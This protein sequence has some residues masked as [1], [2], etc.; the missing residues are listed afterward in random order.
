M[1]VKPSVGPTHDTAICSD[2][3]PPRCRC[4]TCL[5]WVVWTLWSVWTLVS[6]VSGANRHS[7]GSGIRRKAD[8]RR[9]TTVC[10][11]ADVS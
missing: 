5:G 2:P 1:Y 11:G 8:R 7:G 10:I 9:L 3:S 6:L 4:L